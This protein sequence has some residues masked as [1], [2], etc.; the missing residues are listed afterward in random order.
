MRT[1]DLNCLLYRTTQITQTVQFDKV[2]KLLENFVICQAN[3]VQ[4]A[5]FSNLKVRLEKK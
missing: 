5:L 3:P 1:F 4:R 2:N